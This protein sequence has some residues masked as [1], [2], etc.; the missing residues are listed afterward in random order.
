MN[1]NGNAQRQI[2]PPS[3]HSPAAAS[4]GS[5]QRLKMRI[6]DWGIITLDYTYIVSRHKVLVQVATKALPA[7]T[8]NGVYVTFPLLSFSSSLN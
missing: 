8:T 7:N 3:L 5:P 1:G 6:P 2:K 4:N